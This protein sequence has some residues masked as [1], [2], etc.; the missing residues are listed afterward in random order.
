VTFV[1]IVAMVM[2][3]GCVAMTVGFLALT[4]KARLGAPRRRINRALRSARLWPLAELP[5]HTVGRVVGNVRVLGQPLRAP[6]SGRSCVYYTIK[7]EDLVL[8]GVPPEGGVARRLLFAEETGVPFIIEDDSGRA[9]IDPT[10]A[11]VTLVFDHESEISIGA[12]A[13][14]EQAALLVRHAFK[15][16]RCDSP[17]Y[18]SEG[19]VES[20]KRIA[21]LGSG[22]RDHDSERTV[23]SAYRD[24]P[25]TMLRLTSTVRNALLISDDPATMEPGRRAAYGNHPA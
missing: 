7:V 19:I 10:G 18:F 11:L 14:P 25:P 2:T 6:L 4:V 16:E 15:T 9:I 13:T 21:V 17:L 20:V 22:I 1:E 8:V 3:G 24:A 12:A 23:Q 5:A